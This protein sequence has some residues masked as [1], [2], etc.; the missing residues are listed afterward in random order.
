[1]RKIIILMLVLGLSF[2]IPSNAQELE[3]TIE[4]AIS[5][6]SNN[7]IIEEHKIKIVFPEGISIETKEDFKKNII[8]LLDSIEMNTG[9]LGRKYIETLK[10]LEN[11]LEVYFGSLAG[12]SGI[13]FNGIIGIRPDDNF[14]NVFIHE[15][16]HSLEK[17]KVKYQDKT[18]TKLNLKGGNLYINSFDSLMEADS[19]ATT[20]ILIFLLED[21][22]NWSFEKNING[23]EFAVRKSIKEKYQLDIEKFKNS[24]EDIF[25]IKEELIEE[26]LRNKYFIHAYLMRRTV[27]FFRTYVEG[28]A[29]VNNERS[30][31][32]RFLKF[33][34][35][36]MSECTSDNEDVV[37][38]L[39]N[40][41]KNYPVGY[42]FDIEDYYDESNSPEQGI[43]DLIS[44]GTFYTPRLDG[45]KT[46]NILKESLY[47]YF[48]EEDLHIEDQKTLKSFFEFEHSKE[49]VDKIM[50]N[51]K[52]KKKM[53]K[54]KL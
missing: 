22:K 52:I 30:I 49:C 33:K 7:E 47:K 23:I 6:K 48:N 35:I 32:Y 9:V 3:A 27:L 45:E 1:M 31:M 40:L 15:I 54:N 19:Y 28:I 24:E 18:I 42:Y 2:T 20:A 46:A 4:K 10:E 11:P 36:P 51:K 53:L 29:G 17:G 5:E 12:F 41:V 34:D 38:K 37:E 50:Q 43:K 13:N 25:K 21:N 14:V 16:Y 39:R 44:F 26:V 8:N